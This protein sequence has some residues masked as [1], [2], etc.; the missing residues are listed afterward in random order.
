MSIRRASC[1]FNRNY[2]DNNVIRKSILVLLAKFLA[3]KALQDVATGDILT[4]VLSINRCTGL[5]RQVFVAHLNLT[6]TLEN[7]HYICS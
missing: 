3:K 2:T 7:G 6:E 5:F 4:D 1:V